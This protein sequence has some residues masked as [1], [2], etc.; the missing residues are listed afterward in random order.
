MTILEEMEKL[1]KMANLA[2]IGQSVIKKSN[3]IQFKVDRLQI[4]VGAKNISTYRNCSSGKM[5]Q[6]FLIPKLVSAPLNPVP[7][8]EYL[9]RSHPQCEHSHGQHI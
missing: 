7:I 2:I 9:R 6:M 3:D 5:P 4:I 8:A 1:V